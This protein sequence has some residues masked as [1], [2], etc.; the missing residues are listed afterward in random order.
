MESNFYV[1]ASGAKFK[2]VETL[3]A[4]LGII[5]GRHQILRNDVVFE[6]ISVCSLSRCT[7]LRKRDIPMKLEIVIA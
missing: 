6:V 1:H 2:H 7:A 3:V 4:A 5:G